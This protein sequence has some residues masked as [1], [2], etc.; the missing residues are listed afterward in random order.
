MVKQSP[1]LSKRIKIIPSTKRMVYQPTGSIYQVLSSEVATKHGQNVSAC[2]FDELHTQPNRALYDV[3]T[4]GSGDARKQPL[5]FFLTTAGTDRN[6][7]CWEVHQ[8]A[9]DILE[10]RKDDPR[11]YPVVFGLPDDADWTDEKNWYKANPSLDQTI[12]IDKVRDAF[13]KA[14]ETPADENMFRQLR[15]NQ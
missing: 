3:M 2:I 5:W 7:I 8:K 4:Q 13:R 15:L 14:Q 9:L 1:A 10:G 12:T 6:S 11:F